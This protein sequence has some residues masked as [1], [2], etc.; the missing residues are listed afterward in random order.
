MSLATPERRSLI[1]VISPWL[2]RTV[3]YML[4]ELPIAIQGQAQ[5]ADR[6]PTKSRMRYFIL[7]ILPILNRL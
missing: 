2:G 6:Y 4:Q 1:H 7:L 3:L 5:I